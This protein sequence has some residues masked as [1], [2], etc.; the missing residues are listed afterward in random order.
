[1]DPVMDKSVEDGHL[2]GGEHVEFVTEDA[3]NFLE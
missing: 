2:G 1:L 3:A